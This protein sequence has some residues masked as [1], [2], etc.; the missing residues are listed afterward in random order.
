[1]DAVQRSPLDEKSRVE[2]I[3]RRA[4]ALIETHDR[5]IGRPKEFDFLFRDDVLIVRGN[6]PTYHLKQVVQCALKDL[7]GVCR[8][9]NQIKVSS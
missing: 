8:I 3:E 4:R 6:V 1:M 7:E 5:F 2:E 9:D